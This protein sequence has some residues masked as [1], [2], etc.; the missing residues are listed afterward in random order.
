M[1]RF[2]PVPREAIETETEKA[3]T[4][5]CCEN[6]NGKAFTEDLNGSEGEGYGNEAEPQGWGLEVGV[7]EYGNWIGCLAV[8][9]L[10]CPSYPDAAENTVETV[11]WEETISR[12]RSK[13]SSLR[14]CS[15]KISNVV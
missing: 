15:E 4:E 6:G 12:N 1:R 10:G 14:Y 2:S 5:K 13:A 11:L 3:V 9:I 8:V 7:C